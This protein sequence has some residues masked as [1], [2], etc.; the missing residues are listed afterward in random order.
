MFSPEQI[1]LNVIVEVGR[2]QMT[3]EQLMKLEPG[4]MLDID[5]HPENG[6][7]LTIQGKLVGKESLSVSGMQ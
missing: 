3:M 2:I 5:I 1:P 7:N 6:V 4:N